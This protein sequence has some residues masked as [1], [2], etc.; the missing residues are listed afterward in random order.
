MISLEM[1]ARLLAKQ[2]QGWQHGWVA[3][4]K[5]EMHSWLK[6]KTR[7]VIHRKNIRG[8]VQKILDKSLILLLKELTP[9]NIL[10]TC[11][12]QDT[13]LVQPELGSGC[14]CQ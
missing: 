1:I 11:S 10:K 7:I 9:R 5:H 14:F 13:G 2:A 4:E 3:V 8:P 6:T 12:D